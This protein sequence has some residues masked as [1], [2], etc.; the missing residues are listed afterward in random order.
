MALKALDARLASGSPAPTTPSAPAATVA[1]GGP[2]TSPS[3]ATV[4]VPPTLTKAASSKGVPQ[5]EDKAEKVKD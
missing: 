4:P 5:V 1:T 2:S 3:T